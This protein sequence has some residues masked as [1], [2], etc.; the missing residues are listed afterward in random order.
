MQILTTSDKFIASTANNA[1]GGM[2]VM[3]KKLGNDLLKRG[4]NPDSLSCC[5]LVFDKDSTIVM[6]AMGVAPD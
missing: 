6:A 2:E 4:A 5:A 3:M 1:A